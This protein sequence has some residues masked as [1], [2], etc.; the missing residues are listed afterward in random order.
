MFTTMFKPE[1]SKFHYSQSERGRNIN[2]P[3]KLKSNLSSPPVGLEPNLMR[4]DFVPPEDLI[5]IPPQSANASWFVLIQRPLVNDIL[6][7]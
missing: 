2:P 3:S 5:Y 4:L 6:C 1:K 7:V